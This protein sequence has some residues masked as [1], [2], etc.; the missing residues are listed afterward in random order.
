MHAQL[1]VDHIH[2][3]MAHAAT[4]HRVV[5]GVGMVTDKG[6]DLGV[7]GGARRGR[8]FLAAQAR[9]RRLAQYPAHQLE[10]ANQSVDVVAVP[11]EVGVD[12][13][14]GHRVLAGQAQA[15]TAARTQQTDVAGVAVPKH[16]GAAMVGQLADDK[17]QLQI[18]QRLVRSAL[19]EPASLGEVGGEHA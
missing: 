18:G 8:Q 12:Q 17:V 6:L 10:A 16:R 19:D 4:A 15:A 2:R 11:Q 5:D 1:G 3:P 14:R 7:R 9:Q 13:R